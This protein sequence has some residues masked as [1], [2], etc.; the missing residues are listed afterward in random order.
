M[1]SSKK[2]WIFSD[3]FCFFGFLTQILYNLIPI[4]FIIQL[5]HGVLKKERLSYI[6]ILCLYSTA[7]LYF[8]VSIY[9]RNEGDEIDP[10]D[11][12]NMAGAYLGL[13][14]LFIYIYFIYYITNKLL[15]IILIFILCLVSAG[16]FLLIRNTVDNKEDNVWVKIYNW[17]GVV[18]NVFENLPLGFNIIYLIKNKISE[19]YT[20]FGAFFGLINET[21]WLSWA[22][23]AIFI[24]GDNLIHSFV[25]NILG[26]TIQLTQFFI[27]FKFRNYEDDESSEKRTNSVN[28]YEIAK[29]SIIDNNGN[30]ITN[31]TNNELDTREESNEPDYIQDLL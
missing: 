3:A 26:I 6:G 29:D 9:R 14:Y 15:G 2:F 1:A 21:I 31:T 7:F 16:V 30:I 23:N 13:I 25:A 28:S 19:K 18:F 4:V 27:F 10:L 12:C 24:N 5:K 11:F 17:V 22:I 8:W 20:L